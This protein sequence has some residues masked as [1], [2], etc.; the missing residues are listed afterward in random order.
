MNDNLLK[1]LGSK[2][3]FSSKEHLALP[4]SAS[5]GYFSGRGQ[6]RASVVPLVPHCLIG[7]T[8]VSCREGPRTALAGRGAACHPN[9]YNI[10]ADVW[11]SAQDVVTR[12]ASLSGTGT[13]NPVLR[14]SRN[15]TCQENCADA[16]TAIGG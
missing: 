14:I 7:G 13:R 2:E 5:A 4:C 8:L 11:D 16:H 10:E 3:H 12:S 1:P 6:C 9:S 15:S